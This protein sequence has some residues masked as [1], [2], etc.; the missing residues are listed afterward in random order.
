MVLSLLY[1]KYYDINHTQ[2]KLPMKNL[3]LSALFICVCFVQTTTAQNCLFLDPGTNSFPIMCFADPTLMDGDEIQLTEAEFN[4]DA[5]LMNLVTTDINGGGLTVDCDM[6]AT[7]KV[8]RIRRLTSNSS[9][10]ARNGGATTTITFE[11]SSVVGACDGQSLSLNVR[12][13]APIPTFSQWGLLIFALL[14]LNLGS[15]LVWKQRGIKSL[16]SN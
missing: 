8:I 7:V 16:T 9:A 2:E 5:F 11:T 3:L 1:K 15:I 12:V 13:L 6:N 10:S 14:I 4:N